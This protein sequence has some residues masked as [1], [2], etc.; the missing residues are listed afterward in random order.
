M[1]GRSNAKIPLRQ[2]RI[3]RDATGGR[4]IEPGWSLVRLEPESGNA[5][6]ERGGKRVVC[7]QREF[8]AL[9][10]PGSDEAWSFI[11]GAADDEL[12]KAGAAWAELDLHGAA[13]ALLHYARE[14]DPAF[15]GIQIIS[16]M[17]EKI[18]KID[19]LCKKTL[20]LLRVET[21]RKRDEYERQTA[22]NLSAIDKKDETLLDLRDLEDRYAAQAYR[23]DVQLPEWR[24]LAS[25][26]RSFDA[27]AKK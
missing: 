15:R 16:D 2:V 12:K 26:I 13:S 11:A 10:F 1:C 8:E 5:V 18:G 17:E 24:R 21:K 14:L 7:P 4:M 9:N 22:S 23:H 20:D 19:D 3:I 6:C 25:A 27:I